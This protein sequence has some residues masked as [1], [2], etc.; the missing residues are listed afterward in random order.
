MDSKRL[1]TPFVVIGGGVAGLAA[2]NRLCDLGAFPLVIEGGNY[3]LSKV[4]GE[5]L[6]YECL[7]VLRQWDIVPKETVCRIAFYTLSGDFS[8]ILPHPGSNLPR[9]AIETQ[10]KVRAT[11]KGAQVLTG[12][13]VSHCHIG[14]PHIL[15]THQG[16]TIEAEHL[17]CAAGR[18]GMLSKPKMQKYTGFKAHIKGV[19]EKEALQ[20]FVIPEGYLGVSQVDQETLNV[21]ILAKETKLASAEPLIEK[22]CSAHP[23]FARLIHA[24]KGAE[25]LR[26]GVP[27]FGQKTVPRKKSCYFIG[28]TVCSIPPICGKGLTLGILSAVYAADCAMSKGNN[29]FHREWKAK[30]KTAIF[31]GKQLHKAMFRPMALRLL[32]QGAR[33]FPALPQFL[34]HKTKL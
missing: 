30:T 29:D 24:L 14:P 17:I 5:F 27:E 13:R 16:K 21:A 22:F 9:T 33:K 3:P 10:L 25:W 2:A 18:L 34:F 15:Q 32:L 26:S 6:S 7:P 4:C 19:I 20:M 31:W 12:T 1:K 23:V 8:F 11:E 28:D